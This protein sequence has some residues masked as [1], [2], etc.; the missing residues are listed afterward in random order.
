MNDGINELNN[1][2][3]SLRN[4]IQFI[5][6]SAPSCSQS[7]Q[8]I[9]E[10][11]T[12]KADMEALKF[13]IRNE[14]NNMNQ[15]M[16][17]NDECCV[18]VKQVLDK[19][20]QEKENEKKEQERKETTGNIN[21]LKKKIDILLQEKEE[22]KKK[23]ELKEKNKC[24]EE[25]KITLNQLIKEKKDNEKEFEMKENDKCC[26]EIKKLL[27]NLIKEK[28][29]L[30]DINKK[31]EEEKAKQGY[32]DELK[33]LK[34][35]IEQVTKPTPQVKE[36]SCQ[37]EVNKLKKE[38]DQLKNLMKE[39]KCQDDLFKEIKLSLRDKCS[40]MYKKELAKITGSKDKDSDKS[41]EDRNFQ[42]LVLDLLTKLVKG[43]Q[44]SGKEKGDDPE[45]KSVKDLKDQL[46]KMTKELERIKP[47]VVDIDSTCK[48]IIDKLKKMTQDYNEAD[49][50]NSE[51]IKKQTNIENYINGLATDFF[52]DNDKKSTVV[53]KIK[54][55]I[56]SQGDSKDKMGYY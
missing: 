44:E 28:A 15:G 22:E 21:D 20:V 41:G 40:D 16:K 17:Y 29:E 10:I 13:V 49:H 2:L 30:S 4:D 51:L 47:P 37:E 12:L 3:D 5:K 38:I 46:D 43:D 7:Y 52:V 32:L 50:Q 18:K 14:T 19:L 33:K 26:E 27:E 23:L 54:S 8:T 36:S 35:E 1:K 24:C 31:K 9:P 6:R 11:Q 56:T 55:I 25:I 45:C 34:E 48:P 53:N 42:K 39:D